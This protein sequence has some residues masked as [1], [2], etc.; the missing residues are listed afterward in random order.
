[1]VVL[2]ITMLLP[3]SSLN[4]NGAGAGKID[5][6]Y[7]KMIMKRES[8][9]EGVGGFFGKWRIEFP[10]ANRPRNNDSPFQHPN[11]KWLKQKTL[12]SARRWSSL[13]KLIYHFVRAFVASW[14]W[15]TQCIWERSSSSSSSSTIP[16]WNATGGNKWKEKPAPFH[17]DFSRSVWLGWHYAVWW[18]PGIKLAKLLRF[19]SVVSRYSTAAPPRGKVFRYSPLEGGAGK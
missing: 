5:E 6:V 13:E 1:M 11:G 8:M 15:L 14:F 17:Q 4:G 7:R 9:A 10:A 2:K 16:G 3:C 18:I 12:H 19:F